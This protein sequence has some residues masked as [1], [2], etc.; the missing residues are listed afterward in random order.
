MQTFLVLPGDRRLESDPSTFKGC[1]PPPSRE[2][3]GVS[4][5]LWTR[6]DPGAVYD[7]D[8]DALGLPSEL[9]PAIPT[10]MG[11]V[12]ELMLTPL[13]PAASSDW[14]VSLA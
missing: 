11:T 9:N 6:I 4:E 13:R 7:E 2:A 10:L 12:S 1:T 14:L 8:L 5:P 3:R